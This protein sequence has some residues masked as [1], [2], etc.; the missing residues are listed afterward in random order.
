MIRTAVLA[1]DGQVRNPVMETKSDNQ[2]EALARER[3][4]LAE[5]RTFAAWIRTGLAMMGAGLAAAKL[6]PGTTIPW[7]ARLFGIILVLTGG[8]V[9][10][11]GFNTYYRS[12]KQLL[13]EGYE[14]TPAWAVGGVAAALILSTLVALVLILL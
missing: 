10:V 2:R 9:F 1:E 4:G 7:L 8:I 5:E 14:L 6:L 3:T 13:Q 11:L 12:L